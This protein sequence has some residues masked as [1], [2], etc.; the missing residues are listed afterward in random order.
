VQKRTK[1]VE[2]EKQMKRAN[3]CLLFF[4]CKEEF[5]RNKLIFNN[6][7]KDYFSLQQQS[8][9]QSFELDLFFAEL[10]VW[11]EFLFVDLFVDLLF[12]FCSI[13]TP[14]LNRARVVFASFSLFIQKIKH[15]VCSALL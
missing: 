15:C 4:V 14:L 1:S 12:L 10:I 8:F 11:F 2:Y 13:I 3:Q 5:C 6:F 7:D 9:P